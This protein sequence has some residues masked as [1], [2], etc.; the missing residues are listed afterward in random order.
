MRELIYAVAL[1]TT[2][3][4]VPAAAQTYPSRPITII[5]PGAAGGPTDT[6]ARITAQGMSPAL[7]Q[8]VLIENL[9]GG[10]GTIATTRVAR[11]DP[12]G[13]TLLVYHVGL[14]TAATLYRKLPFDTRTA[15]AP[16]GVISDAPMTIVGRTDLAPNSLQELITHIKEHGTKVTF[17]HA[18]IGAASHLCGMLFQTAAQKQMT[19]VPYRGTAPVMNDLIGKHIDLSCDQVTNTTN[20]ILA[21]QV[22][23]YAIT[24]KTRLPTL[25]DL[26]TADEA[27]LKG[28]ELG[29]WHGLFAPKGTPDAV[30]QK[31][32]DALKLAVASPDLVKRFND[33]NTLSVTAE[34]ATPQ[35]LQ[36]TLLDEIDRWAPIIHATGEYA[37]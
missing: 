37:D 36:R 33:I 3:T 26:P 25:P 6:I 4:I 29:I 19:N 10:G 13:Y 34:R 23:A 27:G 18:G 20:P 28:F 22:K 35:V 16:I 21:K 2:A 1:V 14:A 8:Q 12:D 17:G 30:V 9:G 31:L 32:S 5:V 24:T 11:A 7:G 15:F